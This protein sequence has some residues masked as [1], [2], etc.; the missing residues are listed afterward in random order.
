[1]QQGKSL[2]RFFLIL[3]TVVC[4]YQFILMLPTRSVE[5]KAIEHAER[6]AAI[7]KADN[8]DID[9]RAQ[10]KLYYTRYID[11]ISNETIFTIPFITS[12]TYE[13]LKQQQLAL[14]LDLKGGMSVVMQIDLNDLVL[15]LSNQSND[16]DFRA[17]LAATVDVQRTQTIDFIQEFGNQYDRIT[18]NQGS[19][20]AIFI[21]NQRM[22]D[23]INFESSNR[24]VLRVLREEANQAVRLTYTRL[25]ERIDKFGVTQPNISLDP[26]TDRILV[27]LPGVENAERARNFL[28]A[29]AQL[30]FW[31]VYRISDPGIGQGLQN[32]NDA[33]RRATSG[34]R[35]S[36]A[37]NDTLSTDTIDQDMTFPDTVTVDT[38]FEETWDYVYDDTGNL[39]DSVLI[40]QPV[41]GADDFDPTDPLTAMDGPLFEVFSPN[42]TGPTGEM[43]FSAAILGVA[44]ERD[45]NRVNELIEMP[46]FRNQFPQDMRLYWGAKPFISDNNERLFPLYS[47]KAERGSRTAPLE[48]DRVIDARADINPQTNEYVVSLSMDN[49]GASIWGRMTR[50]AAAD[51]NRELAIV[52][53]DEVVSAPFVREPITDGRSQISGGFSP[54]EARDLANILQIGKLPTQIEIISEAVVGPTL[55]EQNIRTSITSLIIGFALVLVFMMLYYYGGGI[56]SIIALFANLFFIFGS[57]ASLGTV[58]TLPGIAGIVLT[59]G[60]AVDAN[61]I[62]YERIREELRDGKTLAASVRDGFYNSYSAIIDANVTTIMIA[63]ILF[64]FGLGPIKGFAA[65]LII[66]VLSSL[67][68]AVLLTRLLIDSWIGKGKSLRFSSGWSENVMST[69]NVDW[70]SKRK[71]AY[72]ISG[73]II[74]L[75][76]GSFFIKGFETGVDFQGGYAYRIA[77]EQPQDIQEV[78]SALAAPFGTEPIVKTVGSNRSLEVT[79]SYLINET[80]ADERVMQALYEGISTLIPGLVYEDFTNLDGEGNYILSSNKIGATIAD[81]IRTSALWATIFALLFIFFYIFVRFRKWQF[82]MGAVAALF[83]DVLILL[84]IF[85]IF[86]GIL[87]FSLT[88]DQAFIAALLTVIGYSINDTVVVFDR[89]REVISIFRKSH[90]RHEM[91]NLAVNKTLSR[92]IITSLTTLFVVTILFAFGSGEIQGFAFALMV[93]ILVGTYSSIFVATPI[94]FDLSMKTAPEKPEPTPGEKPE[95]TRV[96]AG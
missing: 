96:K 8:P 24:E 45:V 26:I 19:L 56:I 32:A 47:I 89:I 48:G 10:E 63:I 82:S 68:T 2:I 78:R 33:L 54:Q 9:Y 44:N 81:D 22:Q 29:S 14:G 27:E 23:L 13:N 79:T 18:N 53:D 58:L 43:A 50:E 73:S 76:V 90:T 72:M 92:T 86:Y 6:L 39:V 11:S 36:T 4:V 95:A 12:F 57:L 37:V 65:V 84:S 55:G 94:F 49:Q 17:A 62:I 59:I 52:L 30:E 77:F 91:V 61:V 46:E 28:Q 21:R 20:A 25:R 64:Y 38:T 66:G 15:S 42:G 51:N 67:F 7:E 31:R 88:I 3:M 93:G 80:N 16:A 69:V 87:P 40:T 60:M 41:S 70:L 75:G 74:L 1:M 34:S 71:Y 83:H 35:P 85:S 5:K